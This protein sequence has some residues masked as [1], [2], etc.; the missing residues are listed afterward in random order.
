LLNR[1]R[2][3]DVSEGAKPI[4]RAFADR[5]ID[6]EVDDPGVLVDVDTPDDYRRLIEGT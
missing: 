6:V 3:A 5:A 2:A 1:L 4:V